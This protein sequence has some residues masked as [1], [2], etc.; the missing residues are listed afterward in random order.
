MPDLIEAMLRPSP[1]AGKAVSLPQCSS[2]GGMRREN[3]A[4]PPPI[5]HQ[6]ALSQAPNWDKR[7]P[8]LCLGLQLLQPKSCLVS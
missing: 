6:R 3:R 5:E 1:K 8:F 4:I 7:T 2:L